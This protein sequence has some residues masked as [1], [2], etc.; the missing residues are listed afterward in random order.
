MKTNQHYFTTM[1]PGERWFAGIVVFM[2]S[3]LLSVGCKKTDDTGFNKATPTL[4]QYISNNKDLG[5]YRAA[6]KRARMDNAEAFSTGGPLTVFAP[7]DSAFTRAGLT[8][9]SI[10]KYDP[11][12]LSQV[13]K[14]TLVYGKISSQG[15]VGFYQQDALS[16]NATY[17]PRLNKNYYGIY[18]DGIPLVTNG[19]TDLNDGVLHELTRVA[20]PPTNNLFATINKIP[21]LAIFTAVL[22]KIGQADVISVPPPKNPY[23]PNEGDGGLYYTV[24]A[25]TNDAFKNIGYPDVA[26]I[27]NSDVSTLQR[28]ITE[29]HIMRSKYLTSGFKGGYSFFYDYYYVAA[30][31]F[32]IITK[33]NVLPTHIIGP[34]IIATNGVMQIVDQVI[35]QR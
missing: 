6:L 14:Y 21:S 9:D 2:L 18:F 11:Q 10:G 23:N 19:S 25:P 12:A 1:K 16:K 33:G 20:L 34:D 26:A 30:D 17:K 15:L 3:A 22:K 24:F 29:T 8:L 13:M 27:E 31:G 28:L 5:L 32:T 7:V 35:V 4:F